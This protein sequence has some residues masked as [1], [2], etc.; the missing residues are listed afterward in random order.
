MAPSR[1]LLLLFI[2]MFVLYRCGCGFC[3]CVC[4]CVRI[5]EYLVRGRARCLC[6]I[7]SSIAFWRV[8]L[9][10]SI[11]FLFIVASPLLSKSAVFF[12][13]RAFNCFYSMCACAWF[14]K[15]FFPVC[16]VFVLLIFPFSMWMEFMFIF[17]DYSAQSNQMKRRWGENAFVPHS[18]INCYSCKRK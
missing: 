8:C 16:S 4:V 14:N 6:W 15:V 1:V 10:N 7:G 18:Y 12:Y 11:Y 9:S 17:H 5:V 3:V 2:F 13:P